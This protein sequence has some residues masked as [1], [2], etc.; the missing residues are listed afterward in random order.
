MARSSANPCGIR[1]LNG[2]GRAGGEI[3]DALLGK[4]DSQNT[5]RILRLDVLRLDVAH[6]EAAGASP[7]V[8]NCSLHKRQFVSSL[9]FM[10]GAFHNL[11]GAS[12]L[13]MSNRKMRWSFL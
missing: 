5:G 10:E 8:M 13:V 1:S 9:S 12:M 11:R 3:P 4:K 7:G 6:K 2:D